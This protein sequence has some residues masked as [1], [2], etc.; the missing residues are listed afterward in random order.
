MYVQLVLE[1]MKEKW[2]LRKGNH[3][4]EEMNKEGRN[5]FKEENYNK[6]LMLHVELLVFE[7]I[8]KN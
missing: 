8:I 5:F 3:C 6:Y 2:S 7:A 1:Y 4:N